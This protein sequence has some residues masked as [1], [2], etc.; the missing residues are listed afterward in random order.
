MDIR[1]P[2]VLAAGTS[3]V[4]DEMAGVA[5]L[6]RVGAIVTKSI[7]REPRIG[8]PA[9]RVHPLPVGML[10]AIGLANPGIDAFVERHENADAGVPCPVIGSAA[11]NSID[12]Y[13]EV[14]R[15]FD[16]VGAIAAVELNVSCPNVHGGTDFGLDTSALAE[17]VHACGAATGKPL[18]VKLSPVVQ[19]SPS[20]VDLA[21][22]AIEAGART[23]TVANTVPAMAID[24]DRAQPVLA[25]VTGGLSGPAVHPITLR[26]VHLV[27]RGAARDAGIPIIALGGVT[28][29]RD[30]A[31]Y[32]LAG[33]SAVGVG[34][35]LL[36]DPTSAGRIAAGLARWQRKRGVS[37]IA[38]LVGTVQLPRE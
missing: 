10:N 2:I 5:D 34:T 14:C 29:W 8:N 12:D 24:V 11:G 33:A 18:V 3:G 7:T 31:A 1:S 23:L 17:L 37:A 30:A 26:L 28:G 4:F 36:A 32:V 38:D 19:G 35:T 27:Y 21:K 20:I 13:A 25:N 22:A 9:W 16:R 6:S 15:G